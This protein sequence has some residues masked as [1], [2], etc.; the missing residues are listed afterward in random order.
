VPKKVMAEIELTFEQDP[1]ASLANLYSELV[2][3]EHRRQLGT[4]F[5]PAQ[6][7][8]FMIDLWTETHGSPTSVVDIGAGVGVFTA[9]AMSAWQSAQVTA[10][11]INPVTLGLLAARLYGSPDHIEYAQR[12]SL[13]LDDFTTWLVTVQPA[14]NGRGRLYLGNPPYT[15]ASLLSVETR[16]R[17]RDATNG[18]CGLRASLSTSITALTLQSLAPTDGL[19]LLLPAQWL[20]SDYAAG[21]RDLIWKCRRRV[22]LRLVES[23]MFDD[24]EVDAVV[25]MIGPE[26]D[27][28]IA[29]LFLAPWRQDD[30]EY[31]PRLGDAPRNWRKLFK[32]EAPVAR[33]ANGKTVSLGD[34][35]KVHR[36]VA[37]GANH[38]F[39]L[40]E[41]ERV[42][43]SIEP[44]DLVPVVTRIRELPELI[45]ETSLSLTGD[46][47][48]RWLLTATPEQR[49]SSPAIDAYLA[50]G[51]R[52]EVNRGHLCAKRTLWHDLS[53]ELAKPNVIIG[54]MTRNRFRLIDN[55][56]QASITNNL[57]GWKWNEGVD[58]N[59]QA[60]VLDWFRGDDGQSALRQAA[61]NQGNGLLKIEPRALRDILLPPDLLET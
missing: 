42:E 10:V 55:V 8:E 44:S 52:N 39:L 27:A 5:T 1:D 35:A 53:A 21:L 23:A 17:L 32:D 4:F 40:T 59:T 45:V 25:L 49:K 43:A 22:E 13:V 3:S 50:D 30:L 20:E 18:L 33:S 24:A 12:S 7:A 31:L 54:S 36:G 2:R 28:G 9:A 19:C 16:H 41:A 26:V 29:E 6:E 56:A 57:Y 58:G 15:R 46:G 48:R 11:D 38:F 47:V 14:A 61:R 34:I 37:T 60:A 51:E